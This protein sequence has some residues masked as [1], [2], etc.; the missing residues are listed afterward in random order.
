MPLVA[1]DV[2]VAPGSRSASATDMIVVS[3]TVDAPRA[4]R[5]SS[6][7]SKS[8]RLPPGAF[9]GDRRSGLA[10]SEKIPSS[11]DAVDEARLVRRP[12]PEDGAGP[13]SSRPRSGG[14]RQIH[15]ATTSR[16]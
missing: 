1:S 2:G 3:R 13:A 15:R 11:A 7:S 10:G 16:W 4:E 8:P 5:P 14:V 9:R 12:S 6:A